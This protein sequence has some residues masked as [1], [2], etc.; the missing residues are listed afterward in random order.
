[1]LRC[2]EFEV[3]EGENFDELNIYCPY[4]NIQELPLD[5]R[6]YFDN[7]KRHIQRTNSRKLIDKSSAIIS[8]IDV[9]VMGTNIK[10][11]QI[12]IDTPIMTKITITPLRKK[13][14]LRQVV[15]LETS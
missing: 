14:P 15:V 2:F 9:P 5:I 3:P 13:R 8:S 12:K 10:S 1:M 6:I 7:E 11:V 4:L